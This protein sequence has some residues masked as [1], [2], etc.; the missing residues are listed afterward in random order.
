MKNKEIFNCEI[1]KTKRQFTG[2]MKATIQFKASLLFYFSVYSVFPPDVWSYK[3]IFMYV[4]QW[5][6]HVEHMFHSMQYCT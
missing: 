1:I 5:E 4:R 3:Y 2:V 6:V